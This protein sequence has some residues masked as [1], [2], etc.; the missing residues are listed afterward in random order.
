MSSSA[1]VYMERARRRREVYEARIRTNVETHL[2][3]YET[4]LADLRQQGL[5]TVVAEEFTHAETCLA[6]SRA[7]LSDN[8]EQ[9]QAFSFEIGALLRG[10]P[11]YARAKR[12]SAATADRAAA[13]RE[14]LA[15]ELREKRGR[16]SAEAEQARG[17]SA[18]ALQSLV[19]RIDAALATPKDGEGLQS[20]EAVLKD[21]E[22]A[23]VEV[24]VDEELRKETLRALSETMRHLG[25]AAEAPARQG[26]WIRLRFRN[27]GGEQ[28]LFL[29]GGDGAMK[30]SFDGYRGA[31]CKKDRDRVCARLSD[32]Y[33]VKFSDQRI[34]HEN[35]D[36]IEKS[37]FEDAR[38][39]NAG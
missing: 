38:P 13:R 37:S 14:A 36:E 26:K 15:E 4:V 9:A 7:A 10:L 30:Y 27:L 18:E 21:V 33:G 19:L 25:F 31:A 12:R 6:Q 34:I 24:A 20:T 23:E 3:R 17:V 28:A 5:D 1:E 32:V 16:L 22:K 2:A 39:E 8:V 11:S 29:V 35:P